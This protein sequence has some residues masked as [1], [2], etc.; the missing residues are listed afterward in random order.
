MKIDTHNFLDDRFLL[1][2]KIKQ[3]A[4][5]KKKIVTVIL[6]KMYVD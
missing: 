6:L 4:V 5:I 3:T 2:K 1:I